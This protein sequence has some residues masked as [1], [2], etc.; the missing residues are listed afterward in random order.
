MKNKILKDDESD[1]P[2]EFNSDEQSST[3]TV[4]ENLIN[5]SKDQK[6]PRRGFTGLSQVF[7]SRKDV[8]R[9]WAVIIILLL[10]MISNIWQRLM[11]GSAY[12]FKLDDG[13]EDPKYMMS[14][15]IPGFTK[16]EYGFISGFAFTLVFVISVLISGVVADNLSRRLVFGTAAILWSVTSITTAFSTTLF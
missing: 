8:C 6:K 9:S 13:I 2:F 11:F 4:E 16:E 7:R 5:K 3:G 1:A 12:N 15:A 14:V 10:G